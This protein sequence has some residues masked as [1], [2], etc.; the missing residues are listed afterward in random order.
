MKGFLDTVNALLKK[1][2]IGVW[3]CVAAALCVV[4]VM[5]SVEAATNWNLNKE[6]RRRLEPYKLTMCPNQANGQTGVCTND[7]QT[8]TGS[9]S[10]IEH[11][12][13][14]A[15]TLTLYGTQSTATTYS[16][17]WYSNDT[18]YTGVAG[19]VQK[20]NTASLTN[21]NQ[22]LSFAG[23]QDWGWVE[24]TNITGGSVIITM[25]VAPL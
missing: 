6:T 12:F 25:L 17:D 22:V 2:T 21:T 10:A 9:N 23:L 13:S 11:R 19:D 15:Y 4:L 5:S 7:G 18:G 16:C 20:M 24:C 8:K 1:L 14:G 3:V